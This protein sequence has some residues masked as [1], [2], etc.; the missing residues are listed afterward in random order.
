MDEI[1]LQEDRVLRKFERLPSF[2]DMQAG[3]YKDLVPFP[4][5]N[6]ASLDVECK[7]VFI[8]GGMNSR[9]P[10]DIAEVMKIRNENL[11]LHKQD[12]QASPSVLR[13]A[14]VAKEAKCK[15]RGS[16]KQKILRT[17]LVAIVRGVHA[18]HRGRRSYEELAEIFDVSLTTVSRQELP[19][20]TK[21]R[22]A[23]TGRC[24]SAPSKRESQPCVRW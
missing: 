20:P 19:V 22:P 3:K 24:R 7:R 23:G 18:W 10:R 4:C 15:L 21:Y 8:D 17:M 12:K 1:A 9:P 11:K 5:T 14:L 16:T 2:A 13:A 6:S